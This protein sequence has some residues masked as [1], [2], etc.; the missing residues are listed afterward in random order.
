M[1]HTKCLNKKAF[2]STGKDFGTTTF[3]E[4]QKERQCSLFYFI[5]HEEEGVLF[6]EVYIKN[7]LSF[8]LIVNILYL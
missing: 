3:D 1:K 7:G 8:F 5:F 6:A 2:I 4:Q